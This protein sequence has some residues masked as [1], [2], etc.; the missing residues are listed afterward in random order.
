M[1]FDPL[2]P[3]TAAD[4][5]SLLRMSG[6]PEGNS[7]VF[8]VPVIAPSDVVFIVQA[9]SN[10]AANTWQEIA[11]RTGGGPWIGTASVFTGTP[12]A[13]GTRVPLLVTD[14]AA[15]QNRRFFRFLVAQTPT[16][17]VAAR[18]LRIQR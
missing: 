17:P 2:T 6:T 12:N 7:V 3:L 1:G 9:S 14:S 11:R 16:G 10:L 4:H 8:D 13:D 15:G 18:R 5:A